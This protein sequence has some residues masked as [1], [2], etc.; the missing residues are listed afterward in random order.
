M[1]KRSAMLMAFGLVLTVIVA[2]VAI[3]AGL[4]GPAASAAAPRVAVHR[5]DPKPI[6]KT[7][8]KTVTV[9]KKASSA[10]AAPVSY[11]AAAPAAYAAPVAPP[12]SYA[13]PTSSASYVDDGGHSSGGSHGDGGG[14]D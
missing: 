8:R 11:G 10:P 6:V 5:R 1:N 9:H 3:A 4:T 2:G 13:S 12:V 7:I 14:D